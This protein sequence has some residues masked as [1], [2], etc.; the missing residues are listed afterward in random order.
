MSLPR[1]KVLHLAEDAAALPPVSR[2]HAD[3]ELVA[4]IKSVNIKAR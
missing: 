1:R 3:R 4:V 2:I